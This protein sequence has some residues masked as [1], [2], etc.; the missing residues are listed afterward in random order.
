MTA[1]DVLWLSV[2][3]NLRGFDQ[4]LLRVLSQ[5]TTVAEWQYRQ[6]LDEACSLRNALNLLDDYLSQ[7]T[8]PIHLVGHGTG[9]L[10]GLMYARKYP[11]KIRSLSLLSVGVHPA[12][13]WQAHYYVQREMMPCGREVLLAQ[14]VYT[15]FGKQ[16]KVMTDVLA[17]ILDQALAT[18]L[19]PHSLWQR[20]SIPPMNA[21]VPL[22]VCGGAN[23][24]IAGLNQFNEWWSWLKD[25]DRLWQCPNGYYFFH[26]FQPQQ[27]AQQLLDFWQS[28]GLSPALVPAQS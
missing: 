11:E 14:M 25:G 23:D 8:S 19:S 16:S 15:L 3:P 17:K 10:L 28:I 13:D 6:T 9:G 18:S 7:E 21:P 26:Y 24:A 1:P 12:V 4:P 5:Q 20:V 2:S 27:V 22:I